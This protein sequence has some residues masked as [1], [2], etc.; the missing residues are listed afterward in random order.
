MFNES[1][2]TGEHKAGMGSLTV[3]EVLGTDRWLFGS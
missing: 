1:K 2:A 3:L